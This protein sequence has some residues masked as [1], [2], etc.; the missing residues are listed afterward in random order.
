[1]DMNNDVT[2]VNNWRTWSVAAQDEH[3]QPFCFFVYAEDKDG[4]IAECEP[5]L[6]R[7]LRVTSVQ[8]T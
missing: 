2:E 4:A 6:S 5:E 8:P 7:G 1:M 3:G